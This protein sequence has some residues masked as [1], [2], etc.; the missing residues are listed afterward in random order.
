[1][2][3]AHKEQ[4]PTSFQF[5]F[6]SQSQKQRLYDHLKDALRKTLELHFVQKVGS[7]KKIA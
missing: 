5:L 2:T 3:Q 4:F 7:E 6:F 1:M